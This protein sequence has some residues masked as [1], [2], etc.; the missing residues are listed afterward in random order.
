[1]QQ[2]PTNASS[3]SAPESVV[4]LVPEQRAGADA[5]AAG[6]S[7]L[8]LV[9]TRGIRHSR[10]AVQDDGRLAG[11]TTGALAACSLLVDLL[12]TSG[13]TKD[14]A[15]LAA[16]P[17]LPPSAIILS[18]ADYRPIRSRADASARP[19]RFLGIVPS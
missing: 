15:L 10:I 6:E 13:P 2:E 11:D 14:A 4:I 12:P 8:A 17:L 9:E 3:T 7:L 18:L 5:V 16:G 19:D 1:M